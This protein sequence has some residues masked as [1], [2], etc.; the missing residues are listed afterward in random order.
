MIFLFKKAEDPEIPGPITGVSLGW[1]FLDE[2]LSSGARLRF[3]SRLRFS[4]GRLNL[5]RNIHQ[6]VGV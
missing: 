6:M 5:S 2:A 3:P 4:S 1:V